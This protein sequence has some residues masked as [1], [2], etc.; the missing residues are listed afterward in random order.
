[1]MLELV[2][3]GR[4]LKVPSPHRYAARCLMSRLVEVL[5]VAPNHGFGKGI[6]TSEAFPTLELAPNYTL[7][8][9]TVDREV[10]RDE[11]MFVLYLATR[12]P[13][14]IGAAPEIQEREHLVEV[15]LGDDSAL[16]WG[17]AFLLDLPLVSVCQGPW[18]AA[19]LNAI[20]RSLDSTESV[21]TESCVLRNVSKPVHFLEHENWIAERKIRSLDCLEDLWNRRDELFPHLV[22]CQ[23]VKDQLFSIQRGD[24]HFQSLI[25]RLFQLQKYFG[26]WESGSFEKSAFAKC[27]PTSNATRE[28]YGRRYYFTCPDGMKVFC[29]WHLYLTPGA[30]RIYFHP[31]ADKRRCIIGHIGAKLPSVLYGIFG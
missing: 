3:N 1:M 19:E 15:V 5:R 4:S 17:A 22:F 10:N 7:Q 8:S 21:V 12:S 16:E 2:F 18:E 24:A 28:T 29:G 30:W 23:E 11:R 6:R 9:W 14:L 31:D 25:E 13:F 20:C 26:N 27:N